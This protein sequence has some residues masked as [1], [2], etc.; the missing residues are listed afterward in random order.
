MARRTQPVSQRSASPLDH[1]ARPAGVPDDAILRVLRVP[2]ECEGMRLDRF[3]PSQLRS[4][5]RTRARA[6]IE[7]SAF[8][9]EGRRLRP[10]D[11]VRG[12]DRIA[13]WR[14]AF[15]EIEAPAELTILYEDEHL[16]AIDKPPLMTVH[17]TARH[18]HHTVIKRL[19]AL[20]PGEFFS[21]VHRLDRET[22]GVLLVAR[23]P[24]ADSAF[25]RAL[26]ERSLAAARAATSGGAAPP[27]D[28]TYLAI[29]RGV[30]PEGLV[31]LPLEADPSPL[32]VKMRVAPAGRGLPSRTGVRVLE[33]RGEYA[34]VRCDLFTGRQHQIRVH[35]AH[36]NTPIV[37]DKLYGPDE[38]LLARAADNALTDE[39]LS[40]LELPR[41]ALHAHEYRLRH[42]FTGAPLHISAPLASDLAHFWDRRTA[43]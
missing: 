25:K 35:L 36:M 17:P 12:E 11:R 13:L 19:E 3:L 39:D 30:P 10:S 5:S 37:G 31:D 23:T 7:N 2:P 26:E 38:R 29:T 4:T 1:P 20:R 32:R 14:P 21:L 18:H 27:A 16:L 34:L 40:L 43:S 8:S 9:F 22:S 15:D 41:H 33:R 24:E 28:K 6:I 42:C